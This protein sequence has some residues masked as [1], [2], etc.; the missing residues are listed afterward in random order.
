[1]LI[2]IDWI[3]DFVKTPDMD[4]VKLG[5][6]FTLATAEVEGVLTSGEHLT[7]MCVAKVLE[8]EKHP[9]ADKLNLVTFEITGGEKRKVVC[10]AANVKV[11]MK[12]P[13]AP[14]G[15]VLPGGFELTPKKIRG[16]LSEGMLCSESELG[17]SEESQGIMEL[18]TEAPTG[19]RLDKYFKETP[20][21][22]LDIDNKS[23]TH[24]PDLW[25]HY[26]IAR[27][28]SAIFKNPLKN[29][30]DEKWQKDL[31][32]KIP[33]G[34]SPVKVKLVG[35]S[36]G[37]G[38]YGLTVKNIKV[39]ESPAWMKKR[40]TAIGLRP[41]NSIV[42]ISNY[43]M[44]E[45]G[46]PNHIFD[47]DLIDGD[48]V[49]IKR[50]GKVSSFVTLDE[51]ERKLVPEDTVICDSKKP[52]VIAGLMGGLNSGV[53]EKTNTVFLEVANWKAAQ[54]RK[55][56][57]RLGLR[58]DSSQRYEKSLD[59]HLMK[60]TLLR[61]LDLIIELNPEAEIVG[62]IEYD[63]MKY[64]KD[65]PLVKPLTLDKI[66]SVLGTDLKSGEV[67]DILE[68]LDFHVK[69]DDP[70][71][72]TVPT[73]R[74]T[75]DIEHPDDIIE[76]VGRIIGYDNIHSTAPKWEMTPAR[77]TQA[78][79]L[80]RKIRDYIVYHAKSF[81]VMTYPLVGEKL[82]KN[83]S[84]PLNDDL[85]LLNALSVEHNRMRPSLVPGLLESAGI[86]AKNFSEFRFFELGRSYL[87]SKDNFQD[88]RSQLGMVFYNQ[89]KTPFIELCN[90][91]ETLMQTTNIPGEL[92]PKHPKFKNPLVSEDWEGVHPFEFLNIRV[93]G[94]MV[95]AVLSIHPVLL[96]RFKIK[97]HLSMAILDMTS[98][99]NNRLKDKTK[100]RPLPKFPGSKF[101]CTVVLEKDRP[102]GDVLA[103]MKKVKIKE[104]DSFKVVDIFSEGDKKNLTVRASFIDPEKTLSG[105][106]LAEA[107]KMIMD[108]LSKAGFPLK[109]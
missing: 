67:K 34:N 33:G 31:E 22:L 89:V 68:S 56:S 65:E 5:E 80:H 2:S 60:R 99:E 93:M 71:A 96:R 25:G 70:F 85:L 61:L 41:I 42:D 75:K 69:G 49:V 8:F 59:S 19:E 76:E 24:R 7:K 27:E 105:E 106:F 88:E 53:N 83:A 98:F 72:I 64:W 97:G 46:Y 78:Q 29:P 62:G 103:S 95:G 66:N 108:N 12:T 17:L 94:K 36:A 57:T 26:G 48:E 77:L 9:E 109:E 23:L 39:G 73:Y 4:P 82:Y 20:D 10:G 79:E 28:F 6:K 86:N 52:L 50:V 87:K 15:T 40:L 101:D 47:R 91:V 16:V 43:V 55:T 3:N 100:Y 102:I 21:V 51:E 84:W 81:E 44:L 92:V 11:G 54:V 58:T 18:P 107:Q 30:F 14:I 63:G 74:A 38:Y 45:L 37:I 104:M 32:S 90:N 13:F 1:M 35:D